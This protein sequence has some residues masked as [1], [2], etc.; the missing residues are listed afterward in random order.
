MFQNVLCSMP[1][2]SGKFHENQ[3]MGLSV[4]LLWDK[5]TNRRTEKQIKPT[6]LKT[7]RSP[8]GGGNQ[9]IIEDAVC[10]NNISHTGMSNNIH[11]FFS[12]ENV[13]CTRHG[14]SLKDMKALVVYGVRVLLTMYLVNC[15]LPRTALAKPREAPYSIGM[16]W[17]GF[18]QWWSLVTRFMKRKSG[19]S[20]SDNLALYCGC[21]VD[22]TL[23][24]HRNVIRNSSKEIH[25]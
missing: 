10:C 23:T 3:F 25:F 4:M 12:W 21:M 6:E 22:L 18:Q 15:F 14:I 7:Q 5:Q 20:L 2:L 16:P 19:Y 11:G 17:Q 9:H 13:P 1:D 24:Q 8:L